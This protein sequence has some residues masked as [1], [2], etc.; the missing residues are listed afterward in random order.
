MPSIALRILPAVLCIGK[1]VSVVNFVV[2][3]SFC[4]FALKFINSAFFASVSF[5]PLS[6]NTK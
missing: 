2:E 3:S 5:Q 1:A 4:Q 6:L